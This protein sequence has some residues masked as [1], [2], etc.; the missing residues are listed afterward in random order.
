[1][2]RLQPF[3]V[4]GFSPHFRL[5]SLVTA[6]RDLGSFSFE[7]D[8]LNRHVRFYLNL[9]RTLNDRG[10]GFVSPIVEFSDT[11]LIRALL[12]SKGF[13][14]RKSGATRTHTSQARPN[15]SSPT[16]VSNCPAA[17]SDPQSGDLALIN[18]RLLPQL[19]REYPEAE[20]RF[21]LSRLEGAGYY[22]GICVRISPQ[23][24][25]G[26]RY[27]IVDGGMT[28]W[29]ARLLQNRK[30]RFSRDRDRLAIRVLTLRD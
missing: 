7:A 30:E 29:T 22:S 18:M 17:T 28:D 27:P 12:E 2:V 14:G 9:F 23:A 10:F 8:A 6:G 24:R 1:V 11:R 4:P 16:A 26:N 19:R 5:F 25:D 15:G 13:P 3:D 20:F 21:N